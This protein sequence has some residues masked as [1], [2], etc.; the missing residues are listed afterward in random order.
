MLKVI[1]TGA[2]LAADIAGIDLAQ[3]LRPADFGAIRQ[4]WMQHYVLRVR[5]QS[6]TDDQLMAF[7]RNFGA[8]DRNPRQAKGE[9]RDTA[10][11]HVLVISNVVENGKPI[12]GLGNHESKW[13]TDMS[14]VDIPP[15]ASALY[16]LEV[17]P[18]GGDTSF[19]NMVAAYEALPAATQELITHLSCVHDS[20]LNSVG[21][22]RVGFEAVTDP[23]RTPGAVHPLVRTHP[24]T[25]RQGLFLGRR[26]NAYIPGLDLAESEALLDELWDHATQPC[27]CWT[28]HWKVGDLV[29]WD[30]RCVLHR[31]DEFEGT[32]RRVMHRTQISGDRPF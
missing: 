25:G 11:D 22:L 31:R 27:F 30:N 18:S 5:G 9:A 8:L 12:G 1:P 16:A 32:A 7:S 28:Q 17:P 19:C 13:H 29:L 6:L 21:Q 20:S 26:R 15:M 14:Y 23:R 2:A 24:V 3:P 10:A 4:A